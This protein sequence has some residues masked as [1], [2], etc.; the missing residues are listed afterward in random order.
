MSQEI[1]MPK[2]G[3]TMTNGKITKWLKKEGDRVNAG[4]P[5]AEIE[6]DK[7]SAEVESPADGYILK[8]LA[9][10]GEDR[11]IIAPIAIIGEMDELKAVQS[12]NGQLDIEMASVSRIFI[13]PIAKKMAIENKLEYS[14]IRGTG[15]NGRVQKVDVIKAV[16]ERKATSA[17]S[18]AAGDGIRIS[19]LARK[20]A[21]DNGID[22]TKARGTGPEGRIVKED[23][24]AAIAEG[25]K[26]EAHYEKAPEASNVV[27]PTTLYPVTPTSISANTTAPAPTKLSPITLA[28]ITPPVQAFSGTDDRK[29]PLEGIRKII[30]QRLSQSKHDIPHVY[31]KANVAADRIMELKNKLAETVKIKTGRKLSVNEI[32]IKA[33]AAA[34][35]ECPYINVSLV[36]DEIIYHNNINIGMAVSIEKGL[37]VPV[38][39]NADRKG[40]SELNSTAGELADKARSGKLTPDDI[41]GGTFT[42]SNLGSFGIDEFSAIINP[43]ES[44]ILAVGKA[45]DTPVAENGQVVIKPMM[46]ITLSVDHRVIDGALAAQFMKKLRELLENPY[47]LLI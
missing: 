2:L 21:E 19:P 44:A 14:V 36:N 25:K 12:S 17:V 43:P 33:V 23:V 27:N 10:E 28:P 40:L 9:D 24:L 1:I 29:V 47:L 32:I 11:D 22:W 46:A 18:R 5:V 7:I 20:M 34:L 39:K 26:S 8:I 37:I 42:V 31:F 6:T 16:K 38:I 3:L 45:V 41:T 13:T 30:A 4:E 35:R 15:P